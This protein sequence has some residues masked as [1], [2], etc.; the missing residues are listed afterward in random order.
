[1]G[2][3][4]LEGNPPS[5]VYLK[6]SARRNQQCRTSGG[7]RRRQRS[8]NIAHLRQIPADMTDQFT[9]GGT[10]LLELCITSAYLL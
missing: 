10:D 1:M 9:G 2:A 6:F 7:M 3:P 5:Y 8:R 4:S